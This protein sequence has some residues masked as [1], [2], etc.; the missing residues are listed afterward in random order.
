VRTPEPADDPVPSLAD[1]PLAPKDLEALNDLKVS[2]RWV[3]GTEEV[4]EIRTKGTAFRVHVVLEGS[5][6]AVAFFSPEVGAWR[7]PEAPAAIWVRRPISDDPIKGDLFVGAVPRTAS[8]GE[9]RTFVATKDKSLPS[10]PHTRVRWLR[11]LAFSIEDGRTPWSTFAASRLR[12]LAESLD[13]RPKTKKKPGPA[14]RASVTPQRPVVHDELASLMETTTGALAVQEALQQ[15]RGLMFVAAEEPK[16]LPVGALA[17]PQLAHHPWAKMAD[18][19]DAPTPEPFAVSAPADFYYVRAADLPALFRLLDQVDAWGTAAANVLDGGALEHDLAARYETALA[20]KRGPLTRALGP[21]VVGEVVVVGS[22]PYLREGSDVT[23]MLRVKSKTLVDAAL[24]A[25]LADL[26]KEHAPLTRETRDHGGVTVNVARSADGAISQQRATVD[27]IMLV[28]NSPG[29]LDVVLDTI[30]GKHPRLWNEPDFRF[31]LARDRD[32]PHGVLAYMS[33]RFVG[34]VVGPKQ[35]VLE[36]RREIALGELETPGFAALLYGAM[37]GKS[38]AKAEDLIATKLLAKDE[39][40]HRSGGPITWQPG[41]L[42]TSSWGSPRAM[43]PL[44]DLPV[45]TTVS[46]SEKA[47]YERFSRSYQREWSAYIDPVA[48]RLALD[49]AHVTVNLRELPLLDETEY[50]DLG[51]FVGA[52]RLT[53]GPAYAGARFL[54]GIG[55]DSEVRRG[56]T[57]RVRHFGL[58]NVTFDFLGQWAAIGI[59]DRSAIARAVLDLDEDVLPEKPAP[60]DASRGEHFEDLLT[61]PVYAE[62]AV[63]SSASAALALAA[64]RVMANE[65]IPGMFDWGQ[66]ATHRDVPVVR[67][68]LRKGLAHGIAEHDVSIFY[69]MT[70]GALIVAMQQWVL[71]RLIDQELDGTG[72]REA[73]SKDAVSSQ[74]AIDVA[75][76]PGKALESVTAWALEGKMLE[77]AEGSRA[78][79]EALFRGAPDKSQDPRAIRALALDTFGVAPVTPDGQSYVPS[80]QGAKD[81][82]RGT[83]VAPVWPKVP[84]E[85]SPVA[86]VLSALSRVR[87]EAAFDDEGKND[88]GKSMRSLRA[89]ATFDLR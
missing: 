53:T 55:A 88:A 14:P 75:A 18:M 12:A 42:A 77:S 52:A 58:H 5:Q 47:S 31:M 10:D 9:H 38:P 45:V 19:L 63:K 70:E 62:V 8:P 80:P 15:N 3:D 51:N 60:R 46:A 71:E 33:D 36:A 89:S 35:K 22:D 48:V 78:L 2:T 74:V 34:E 57:E 32:V 84:V 69:A 21:Q 7:A 59:L 24:S 6:G 73:T 82:L 17:L 66:V 56:F 79:A 81:P 76:Q 37:Y 44:I 85:G 4:L 54:I 13:D 1:G 64:A 20:L 72:P 65:T 25:T 11:A 86:K 27:D 49:D 16:T 39:L 23:V 40:K 26:E 43:K 28:S 68:S 50:R 41:G 61:L 67:I 83:E 30:A 29:A 87:A